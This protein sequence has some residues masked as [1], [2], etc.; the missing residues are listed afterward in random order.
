[1]VNRTGAGAPTRDR[2]VQK[3]TVRVV[4]AA[5][6]A[7]RTAVAVTTTRGRAVAMTT[8]HPWAV[9][10]LTEAAPLGFAVPGQGPGAGP[11][12]GGRMVGDPKGDAGPWR[13]RTTNSGLLR[14][15]GTRR[16]GSSWKPAA[17]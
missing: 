9:V 1:M 8:T 10:F 13:S 11:T 16:R 3:T 7:D 5:M 4:Y 2:D 17:S 15:E 14:M 12:A 6:T